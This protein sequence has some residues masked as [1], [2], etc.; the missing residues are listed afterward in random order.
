MNF[1]VEAIESSQLAHSAAAIRKEVFEGEWK[2][3]LKSPTFQNPG[4]HLDLIARVES[5]GEPVAVMTVVETTGNAGLHKRFGLPFS[6]AERSARY[7]Q[8]AV[9]K[10]YRGM[11]IPLLLI[12]EGKRRFVRPGGFKYTWLLFDPDRASA[13][14]L[15]RQLGFQ[16]GASTYRSEYGR[17][18]VLSRNE[19]QSAACDADKDALDYI[20]ALSGCRSPKY[21]GA[22]P[23]G[24]VASRQSG[25]GLPTL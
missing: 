18:R 23:A 4:Q 25:Y 9:L 17:V 16:A 12:L 11:D 19:T 21:S 24:L 10:P 8:L 1:V 7:T 15:C 20:A 2:R 13:S 5:S 22:V 6:T 3:S 14:S